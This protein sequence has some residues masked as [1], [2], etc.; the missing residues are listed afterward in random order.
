[1]AMQTNA[2]VR[3]SA[4]AV[5]VGLVLPGCIGRSAAPS[6][7]ASGPAPA[8]VAK[9]DG[10]LVPAADGLIDDYEDGNGQMATVGGREGYWYTAKDP[11]GSTIEIPASGAEPQD[12]GAGGS[13]KAF[14]IK[15]Q[16]SGAQ[17]AWGVEYGVNPLN[18]KT[19]QYDASKFAGV[20]FKA[21]K[22]GDTDKVRV[23]VGDINTHPN[24]GLC[25]MCYN[26][27]RKDFTLTDEWKDYQLTWG[28]LQQ[29]P[30][31]GDPRPKSITP[32]KALVIS[33]AFEGGKPFE[34]WIDDVTFLECK[35]K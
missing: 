10:D 6:G 14:H 9:C 16:T 1:M 34:A 13:T 31:W 27:F 12:G 8:A 15:G 35:K 5:S 20:A 4:L 2:I 28:E 24:G 18:D 23:N 30:G 21:K 29:R 17:G 3:V 32:D 22:A 11:N 19:L 25:K 33:F 26:H 7:S